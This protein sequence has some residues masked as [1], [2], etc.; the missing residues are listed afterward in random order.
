MASESGDFDDFCPFLPFILSST[1]YP[2]LHST[3]TFFFFTCFPLLGKVQ[4]S[5]IFSDLGNVSK[6]QELGDELVI[7]SP[8]QLQKGFEKI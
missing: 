3:G 6:I 4:S 1:P 5:E 2:D 8:C 7:D